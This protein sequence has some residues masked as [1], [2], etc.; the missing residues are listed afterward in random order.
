MNCSKQPY[1]AHL[2]AFQEQS[3]NSFITL[4]WLATLSIFLYC[5]RNFGGKLSGQVFSFQCFQ[6]W[7]FQERFKF[8]LCSHCNYAEELCGWGWGSYSF[9]T[10]AGDQFIPLKH[11][12]WYPWTF[13]ISLCNIRYYSYSYRCLIQLLFSELALPEDIRAEESW[14]TRKTVYWCGVTDVSGNA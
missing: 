11:D 9:L 10:S 8:S 6:L 14:R 12:S 3:Q 1:V 5:Y 2:P 4:I 7:L 13:F